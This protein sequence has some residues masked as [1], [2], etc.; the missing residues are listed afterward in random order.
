MNQFQEDTIRVIFSFT[1]TD[2]EDVT[3]LDYH[4]SSNRG[5]KSVLLLNYNGDSQNLPE[6]AISLDVVVS[7]VCASNVE[8]L[9]KNWLLSGCG[10]TPLTNLKSSRAV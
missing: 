5:S 10:P 6:D 8:I 1:D 3:G 2:P 9:K 4:G 7:E